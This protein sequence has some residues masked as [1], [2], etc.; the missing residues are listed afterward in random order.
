MMPTRAAAPSARNDARG[1]KGVSHEDLGRAGFEEEASDRLCE[2]QRWQQTTLEIFVA[3][4]HLALKL[5]R[6]SRSSIARI[7]RPMNSIELSR[8]CIIGASGGCPR[9]PVHQAS[10]ENVC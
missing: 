4:A 5:P 8:G 10:A 1:S 9:V 7:I 6:A 3:K 2:P